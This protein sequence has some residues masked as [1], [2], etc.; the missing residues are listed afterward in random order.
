GGALPDQPRVLFAAALDRMNHLGAL[1]PLLQQ[2]GNDGSRMLQ[3]GVHGDHD[4]ALRR[5][6]AGEQ[7]GLLAEVAAEPDAL[8]PRVLGREPSDDLEGAIS[9]AIIDDDDLR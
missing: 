7:R 2:L 6:E 4:L 5:S 8:D 3:I 9:T 1:L